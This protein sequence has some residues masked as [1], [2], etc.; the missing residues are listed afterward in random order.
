[1]TTPSEGSPGRGLPG[2]GPGPEASA[3]AAAQAGAAAAGPAGV[4][5]A[6]PLGGR[7]AALGQRP[8]RVPAPQ[9]RWRRRAGCPGTRDR[10]PAEGVRPGV[11]G[12]GPT[13][14]S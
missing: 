10:C 5:G 1:M 6:G 13:P 3:A 7:R 4:R 8:D 11:R 14:P 9:G 2:R 12:P